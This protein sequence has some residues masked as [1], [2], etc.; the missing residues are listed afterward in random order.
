LD[1]VQRTLVGAGS[2][3]STVE[4]EMKKKMK[5]KK[6]KRAAGREA[7]VCRLILFGNAAM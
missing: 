5:K 7:F 3:P 4:K 6:K 1:A 2:A